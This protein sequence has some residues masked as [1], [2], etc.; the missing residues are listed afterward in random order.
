MAPGNKDR[1]G[2]KETKGRTEDDDRSGASVSYNKEAASKEKSGSTGGWMR[3]EHPSLLGDTALWG[4]VENSWGVCRV[5][6]VGPAGAERRKEKIRKEKE[7]RRVFPWLQGSLGAAGVQ[8]A[9][10]KAG[11][12]WRLWSGGA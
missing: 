4:V 12:S 2:I 8:G 3:Q 9:I 5:R 10:C 7:G 1:P 6:G 11:G